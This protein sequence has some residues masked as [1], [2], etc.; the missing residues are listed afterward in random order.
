MFGQL[1]PEMGFSDDLFLK[2]FLHFMKGLRNRLSTH[3]VSLHR[4]L[5]PVCADELAALLPIADALNPKSKS[6]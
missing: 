3:P 6:S 2:D 1:V 4:D 5:L